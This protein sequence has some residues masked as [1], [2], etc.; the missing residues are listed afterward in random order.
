VDTYLREKCVQTLLNKRVL[1]ARQKNKVFV[2]EIGDTT[3]EHIV[4]ADAVI[5][6]SGRFL[7]GGLIADRTRIREAIFDLPVYQPKNRQIWHSQ[8]F[9]DARGH[10]I[11]RAGLEINDKFQPLLGNGHRA[12]ETLFA[13]GSILAHQ[14]WMRMKCGAGLAIA[15]AYAAVKSFLR[16]PV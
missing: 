12:F 4:K 6:A 7:G 3:V 10:A 15:T 11:N 9:F 2:L 5:L 13:A 16:N 8:T 1:N 14:D